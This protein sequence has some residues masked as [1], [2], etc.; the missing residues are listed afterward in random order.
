M[1]P[2]LGLNSLLMTTAAVV[3]IAQPALSAPS[4]VTDVAI[5][6][7]GS[8]ISLQLKTDVGDRPQIF[9]APRGKNWVTDVINTRLKL[10]SGSQ[11]RQDNPA[12]GIA[13]VQV[14]PLDAN[15]IRIIVTGTD[16]LP[17]GQLVQRGATGLAFSVNA[18]PGVALEPSTPARPAGPGATQ[19]GASVGSATSA[20]SGGSPVA[21]TGQPPKGDVMV[22]NP[23]VTIDGESAVPQKFQP[24][25]PFLPKA[26]APPV[27]DIAISDLTY[28]PVTVDLGTSVRIPRLVLRDAPA[29]EVL[30]LL[31]RAAGLNLA[32]SPAAGE[33]APAAGAAGAGAEGPKISLDVENE[34]VQDVFNSVLRLSGLEANRLNRTVFVSTKLPNDVRDVI[35]RTYRLNQVSADQASGFLVGMGAERVVTETKSVTTV[36]AIPVQ[37]VTNAPPITQTS[38]SQ[39]TTVTPLRVDLKDSTP[40]LRGLQV[41]VDTRLN[42]VTLVGPRNLVSLA[43]SKMV[44]LDLRKRQ[45]AVNV[46]VLDVNLNNQ[47]TLGSSVSSGTTKLNVGSNNGIASFIF[48]NAT[49]SGGINV[50]KDLLLSLTAQVQTGN[51][52]ILTDPTVVVQEGQTAGVELTEEVVTN[53]KTTRETTNGVV[54]TTLEVEKEKAGLVLGLQIERI[55]DNGFVSLSVSP[56]LKRPLREVTIAGFA[57][58][59]TLLAERKLTSGTVRLRDGQSLVLSGIVQDTDRSTISKVPILGDLPLLGALFRSTNRSTERRELVVLVTPQILD[60]SDSSTFGYAYVPRADAAPTAPAVRPR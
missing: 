38:T 50:L 19:Q 9:S 28:Q 54:T 3:M 13:S 15:S 48:N 57:N 49:G 10:R 31:A 1:K 33:G 27:G 45:V 2:L 12:P 55:D 42:S 7:T 26:V 24:V 35:V 40:V 43:S 17:S 29:R 22:P 23:P 8:G 44:E 52:K 59:I 18:D 51:A 56:S 5:Q 53:F 46:R 20:G 41:L 21:Q 39:Q 30:S 47:T 32:F 11:F 36:N 4:E 60:D 34:A 25:P 16:R 14:V 58:A 6:A 37:G